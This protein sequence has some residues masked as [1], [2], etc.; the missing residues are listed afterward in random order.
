MLFI[1]NEIRTAKEFIVGCNLC[2]FYSK[3]IPLRNLIP[4]LLFFIGTAEFAVA[5]KDPLHHEMVLVEGGTFQMGSNAGEV[6]EQPV[7]AVNLSS[8]FIGKYEVTQKQWFAI[9]GSNPS[10]KKNC[11]ECPVEQV[12]W[13]NIQ[14]FLEKLNTQTGKN[15]RLPTEAEWEFAARGGVN[16][17][18]FEFSGSNN[19]DSVGWYFNNSEKEATVVGRKQA[20]ELGIYDMSGNVWEWCSDWFGEYKNAGAVNPLGVSSGNWKIVRGGAWNNTP[21]LCSVHKRN[22]LNKDLGSTDICFRL[23]LPIEDESKSEIQTE[24]IKTDEEPLTYVEQ[25][26]EY[27]GGTSALYKFISENLVYPEDAVVNEIVGKVIVIFVV[28]VD[29]TVRDVTIERGVAGG[30]SLE[31]AAI[32]VCRKFPKFKPAIQN[33]KAVKTYYRLPINFQL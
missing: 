32:D 27:P 2:Y 31:Q 6:N 14:L 13:D 22:W 5:Q 19:I 33:G 11:E 24:T 1:R 30:Q 12:S 28:D 20:N 15:Y 18:G 17:K 7:H 8:F 9:A 23:V 10:G 4:A 29:G 16:S 3:F 25:D 21:R 26:A